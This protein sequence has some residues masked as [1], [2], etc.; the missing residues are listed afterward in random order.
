M[1]RPVERLFRHALVTHSIRGQKERHGKA[2]TVIEETD[3]IHSLI[4]K[5]LSLVLRSE[6]QRVK[7]K[8][9]IQEVR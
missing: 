8:Y 2:N 9:S 6:S 5:F 4:G 7:T 3:T 1:K